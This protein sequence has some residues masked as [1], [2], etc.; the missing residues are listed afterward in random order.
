[1]GLGACGGTSARSACSTLLAGGT[2]AATRTEP[3]A[4]GAGMGWG[5]GSG[6]DSLA[7]GWEGINGSGGDSDAASLPYADS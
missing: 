7:E 2:A 6:M 1:V 3:A 5:S 4:G